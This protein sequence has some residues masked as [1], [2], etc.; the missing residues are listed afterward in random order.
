MAARRE[1]MDISVVS[2]NKLKKIFNEAIKESPEQELSIE[3][4]YSSDSSFSCGSCTNNYVNLQRRFLLRRV[5][6]S[7][8]KAI[9]EQIYFMK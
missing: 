2:K 1:Q 9:S 3:Q 6:N 8:K 7:L 5:I 4:D